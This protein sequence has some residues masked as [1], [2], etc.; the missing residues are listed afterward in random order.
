MD[1]PI[2]EGFSVYDVDIPI[3]MPSKI[4]MVILS[5]PRRIFLARWPEA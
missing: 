4:N 3:L 1:Q 2:H 5:I